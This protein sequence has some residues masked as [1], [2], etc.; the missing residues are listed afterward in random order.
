MNIASSDPCTISAVLLAAGESR[1]MGEFKQLLTLAGKSFVECCVDNL[2]RS[3]ASEVVVVTGHREAEVRRALGA[4]P[5]KFAYNI[6]YKSGMSASV[7]RGLEAVDEKAQAVL[8]A[9]VDQPQI[10]PPI[11]NRVI[12]AYEKAHP[13]IVIPTYEGRN[14]HPIILDLKLREEI[15]S[16]DSDQG[17]RQVVHAHYD[18]IMRIEVGDDSVLKDCDYPEDYVRLQGG[19]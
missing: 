15:F 18:E 16:I 10:G 19:R 8:I 13:S 1:R 11:I 2:L 12:E 6:D 3:R 5:V 14:G 7:A 4:R 17:L 9:L